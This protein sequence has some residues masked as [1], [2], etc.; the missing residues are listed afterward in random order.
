MKNSIIAGIF[1]LLTLAVV[2]GIFYFIFTSPIALL[3]IS[4]ILISLVLFLYIVEPIWEG[5]KK[6]LDKK[7][8]K[9]TLPYKNDYYL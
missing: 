7:D 1:T 6:W 2:A 9:N 4:G 8:G 3:I 5:Y